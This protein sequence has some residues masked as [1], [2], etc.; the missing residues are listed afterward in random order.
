MIVFADDLLS[1]FGFGVRAHQKGSYPHVMEMPRPG[2]LVTQ[3]LTGL[4]EVPVNKYVNKTTRLKLVFNAKLTNEQ[5]RDWLWSIE[6]DLNPK[7]WQRLFMFRYDWIGILGQSLHIKWLQNP[8][9]YYCSERVSN[10]IKNVFKYMLNVQLSPYELDKFLKTNGDWKVFGK[11]I[12]E[13]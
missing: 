3:N 12:P 6:K 10:R 5:K 7:W 11:V 9:S 1:P 8:L 2:V 4:K 13:D